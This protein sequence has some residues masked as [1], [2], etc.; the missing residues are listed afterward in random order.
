LHTGHNSK[1]ATARRPSV[2]S[3]MGLEHFIGYCHSCSGGECRYVVVSEML[4]ARL[5]I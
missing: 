4:F 3:F 2:C 5:K 1:S